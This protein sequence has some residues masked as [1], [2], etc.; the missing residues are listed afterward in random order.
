MGTDNLIK[1]ID[2]NINKWDRR[3]K[4]VCLNIPIRTKTI[5]GVFL[6]VHLIV[7]HTRCIILR[8]ICI[9]GISLLDE[10][11]DCKFGLPS[12]ET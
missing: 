5:C 12:L 2:I 6:Y 7:L 10:P 4:S 9:G 11:R 8:K 3:K 1:N